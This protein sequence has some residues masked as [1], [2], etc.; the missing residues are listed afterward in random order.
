MLFLK[1]SDEL[2]RLVKFKFSHLLVA[3]GQHLKMIN[4]SKCNKKLSFANKPL[5]GYGKLKGGEE[6]CHKCFKEIVKKDS[7]LTTKLK[8]YTL[9]ELDNTQ[10]EPAPQE[11][12]IEF[13][14]P[15]IINHFD[16]SKREKKALT[17]CLGEDEDILNVFRCDKVD[18]PGITIFTEFRFIFIN[19]G[20][21]SLNGVNIYYYNQISRIQFKS[22]Q[23][24]FKDNHGGYE[25]EMEKFERFSK[26]DFEKCQALFE[27][28][29]SAH[30][31]YDKDSYPYLIGPFESKE[32]SKDKFMQ[33]LKDY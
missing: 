10:V 27:E 29:I 22:L 3:I 19:D 14:S 32:I 9:A 6:I 11:S 16:L 18:S 13:D 12:S 4:C 28:R 20:L 26:M 30:K 17:E 2:N 15:D 7:S 1:K 25:G 21:F 8:N 31:K 24:K 33:D 5:F 23:L